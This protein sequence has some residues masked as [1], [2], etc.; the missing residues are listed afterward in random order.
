MIHRKAESL[1]NF[2][3][4]ESLKFTPLACLSRS[5]IGVSI[6]ESGDHVLIVTLP[7][8]PKAVH[9]NMSILIRNRILM[10]TLA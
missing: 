7:G 5:V 1:V 10:H 4:T 3:Q 8:K 2:M 6:N 9:E